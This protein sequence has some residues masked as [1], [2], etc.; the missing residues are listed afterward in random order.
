MTDLAKLTDDEWKKRYPNFTR[1]EAACRCGCG[2]YPPAAIMDKAQTLRYM[3]GFPLY[4]TSGA[5]CPDHNARE[6]A[7]NSRT[8][9]H[10]IGAFDLSVARKQAHIVIAHGLYL[11]ATGIGV[12]QHGDTRFLHFDW[13]EDAPDQPRPTIWSYK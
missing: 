12:K 3:C 5:R 11:G 2:M 6:S 13:L 4:M 1:A 9:P 10:T 7:T 8:G